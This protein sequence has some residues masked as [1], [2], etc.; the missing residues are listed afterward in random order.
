MSEKDFVLASE[1][2]DEIGKM[3]WATIKQLE[4]KSMEHK[5]WNTEHGT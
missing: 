4:Q 2:S 3:L 1:L 5:A